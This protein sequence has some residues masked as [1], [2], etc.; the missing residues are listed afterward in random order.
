M[1]RRYRGHSPL[2]PLR[3]REVFVGRALQCCCPSITHT[4]P[5]S[6]R[7]HNH[8]E[9]RSL[10]QGL[11]SRKLRSR[12]S[13]KEH[14]FSDFLQV[15]FSNNSREKRKSSSPKPCFGNFLSSKV[16]LLAG[17]FKWISRAL[18]LWIAEYPPLS[19]CLTYEKLRIYLHQLKLS[20]WRL[21]KHIY[22]FQETF[23]IVMY[24]PVTISYS[25]SFLPSS[26]SSSPG[27][28]MNCNF[29]KKGKQQRST[30]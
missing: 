28:Q 18:F 11:H 8:R 6:H 14:R 19:S 1:L 2:L 30:C 22:N 15:S 5:W 9:T 12:Q 21:L 16:L 26:I 7:G 29:H 27:K 24:T 4:P 20:Y 3:L 13:E 25:S 17:E 10:L 23:F